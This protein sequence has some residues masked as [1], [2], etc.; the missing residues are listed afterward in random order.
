MI[1]KIKAEIDGIV[2]IKGDDFDRGLFAGFNLSLKWAEELEKTLKINE[3][4]LKRIIQSLLNLTPDK[5]QLYG[6][7]FEE[8]LDIEGLFRK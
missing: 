2:D 8:Y 5:D 3:S 7:D 6:K 4:N 1:N